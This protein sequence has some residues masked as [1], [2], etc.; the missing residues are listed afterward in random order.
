MLDLSASFVDLDD[1]RETVHF[2]VNFKGERYPALALYDIPIA[3]ENIELQLRSSAG[4]CT[5]FLKT[6]G[7]SEHIPAACQQQEDPKA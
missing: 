7:L 6:I 5:R 3:R 2:M 4:L 1:S